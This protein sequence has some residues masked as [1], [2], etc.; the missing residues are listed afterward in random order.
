M[1]WE[2]G[3]HV[4]STDGI[5]RTCTKLGDN[6]RQRVRGE[7]TGCTTGLLPVGRSTTIIAVPSAEQ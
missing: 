2:L 4:E 7:V 5:S 1:N 6:Q 3:C